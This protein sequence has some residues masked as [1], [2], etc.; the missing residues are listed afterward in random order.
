MPDEPT[1]APAETAEKKKKDRSP[2]YPAIGLQK[3][4]E[5]SEKLWTGGVKQHSVL[6]SVA[7]DAMGYLP[8]SSVGVS[9]I[10]AM[11]KFGL[12]EEEGSKEQR[13]VRLTDF[14]K[15]ILNPNT[16]NKKILLQEAALKPTIHAELWKQYRGELPPDAQIKNDLTWER[17]FTEGAAVALIEEFRDTISFAKLSAGDT[18]EK[19]SGDLFEI[20]PPAKG[21]VS[22]PS[23]NAPPA[24]PTVS[25]GSGAKIPSQAPIA[26]LP[27]APP[28]PPTPANQTL[29]VLNPDLKYYAIPTDIGDAHIPM[30]MSE[31]DF[32]LLVNALKLFKKK[33]VRAVMPPPAAIQRTCPAHAIWKNQ[34]HDKEVVIVGFMGAQDGR[35]Y[36]RSEDGPG[37]PDDELTWL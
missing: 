23:P 4:I 5:N 30:G 7:A 35:G 15:N 2:A 8:T 10:S 12:L 36:W 6:I 27:P 37:I 28:K 3:A 20:E 13:K 18:V 34:D 19:P 9:A 14:A 26:P 29:P 24:Q 33:I 17:Q 31:E 25:E 16:P 11:K 32:E 21:Q 22:P 1:A